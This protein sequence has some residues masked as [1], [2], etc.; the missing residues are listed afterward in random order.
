MSDPQTTNAALEQILKRL[1]Q[2]ERHTARPYP[3]VSAWLDTRP[4]SN[5]ALYKALS[6]RALAQ[7]V[8]I[9]EQEMPHAMLFERSDDILHYALSKAERTGAHAEF[10]VYSGRTIN[11]MA[12]ARPDIVFDGFDSF[13]GLPEEWA[14]WL[15]LDFD[16]KGNMPQVNTNVRLHKGWFE[17]TLPVYS[18]QI[19]HL[20]FLHIDC[21]IYSSTATIFRILE[22]KIRPNCILLFD[23]YFCY[24][25]FQNH[26]RRAFNEFLEHTGYHA[27]WIAICGQ[28]AACELRTARQI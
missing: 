24:P 15:D 27:H 9:V 19:D 1:E 18:T 12:R 3:Q 4:N 21:D 5:H 26:E 16:R 13:E 7:S 10:G 25:N 6:D 22:P 17:D 2:I 14:G 11:L 8:D 28:R 20:S 23:E